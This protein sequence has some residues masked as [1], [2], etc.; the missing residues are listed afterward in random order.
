MAMG[1]PEPVGAMEVMMPGNLLIEVNGMHCKESSV[2]TL[3]F[4]GYKKLSLNSEKTKIIVYSSL[5]PIQP[6]CSPFP[7]LING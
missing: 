4:R 2:H 6:F 7:L 3:S 1:V 5:P